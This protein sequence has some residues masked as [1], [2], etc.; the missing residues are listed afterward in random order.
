M[1]R[2]R[3]FLYTAVGGVGWNAA[4]ISAGYGCG[5]AGQSVGDDGSA[6]N[7]VVLAAFGAA[8]SWF[9]VRRLRT[10]RG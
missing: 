9:V 3:F 1:P 6:R 10:R 7:G 8:I 5:S 2:G 4:L